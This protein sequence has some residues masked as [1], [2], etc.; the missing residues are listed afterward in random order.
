MKAVL[1][2]TAN[3]G[4]FFGY[5]DD[6]SGSTIILTNARNC[7]YWSKDVKGF[8][9]LASHGPTNTCRIGRQVMELQ[10]RNITSVAAVSEE[11]IMKWEA[12][13]WIS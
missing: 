11:A 5:T 9:G 1:V 6:Y 10:L 7:L 2:T 4:V 8:L 13:P 3:R 12:A